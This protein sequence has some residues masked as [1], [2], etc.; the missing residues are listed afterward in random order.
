MAQSK[1]T[2]IVGK[3]SEEVSTVT[4]SYM[5]VNEIFERGSKSGI[6]KSKVSI[7]K[8]NKMGRTLI[9][10]IIIGVLIGVGYFIFNFFHRKVIC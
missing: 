9:I 1:L 10:C 4:S 2:P 6:K 3:M 7:K 8:I 5:D